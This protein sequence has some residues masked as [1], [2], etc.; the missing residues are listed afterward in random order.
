L[1]VTEVL[2][3]IP[4]SST[5]TAVLKDPAQ[6][7]CSVECNECSCLPGPLINHYRMLG[8]IRSN[9]PCPLHCDVKSRAVMLPP[10]LLK[11]AVSRP[12]FDQMICKAS[13]NYNL[14]AVCRQ[15]PRSNLFRDPIA[16]L[17]LLFL[18]FH[19]HECHHHHLLFLHNTI[20]N[21]Y[22]L[23]HISTALSMAAPVCV[24]MGERVSAKCKQHLLP[25]SSCLPTLF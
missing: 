25:A 9:N 4:C 1:I 3:W 6:W 23:S 8:N 18:L 10:I 16:S 12:E 11:A 20:M 13:K 15:P 7:T 5:C 14:Y 2:D 22:T 24:C 19:H 17:F 21:Y